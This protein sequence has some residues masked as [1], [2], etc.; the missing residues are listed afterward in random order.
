MHMATWLTGNK[1]TKS[2]TPRARETRD[3]LQTPKQ[4][5]DLAARRN[6]AREKDGDQDAAPG[7]VRK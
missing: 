5:V 1:D 7:P 3:Q 2:R 6:N 4:R